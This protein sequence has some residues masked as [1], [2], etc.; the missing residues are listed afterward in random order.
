MA[1][2]PANWKAV[3]TLALSVLL[4]A[5]APPAARGQ[6]RVVVTVQE[7][8][9]RDH[10]L[11]VPAGTEVVWGDAHFERVWF[12]AGAMRQ[13]SSVPSWDSGRYS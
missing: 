7:L 5:I 10:R 3:V 6:S 12:P 13:W 9:Q 11:E 8:I 4:T 2:R 1:M